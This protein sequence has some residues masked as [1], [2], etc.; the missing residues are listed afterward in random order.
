MIT[1]PIIPIWLMSIICV[2]LLLLKKRGVIPYIRQMIMIILLFVI[3][4]RIMVPDGTMTVTTQK[5]NTKVLFVVD[6]T[7][8][9]VAKDDGK[10]ERLDN[11][12]EDCSYIL[13]ELNGAKFAVISFNNEAHY[14]APFTNNG[15]YIDGVIRAIYP[16]S[17]L[18]A[19]GSSMN[20][21]RTMATDVLK[22][23][24]EDG[25]G[26]VV[27]FF[28]SDGEIT[29]N[30][31]LDNFMELKKYVDYG[32]VLGYGTSQGGQM[33]MQGV[34][35]EEKTVVEDRRDYPYK[36]A[37]SKIDE[38]NLKQIAKDIGINYIH[39]EQSSDVDR[40]LSEIKA[41]AKTE[42][43]DKKQLGYRDIYYIFVVPF[44]LLLMYEIYDMRKRVKVI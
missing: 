22:G 35:D 18:Y 43:Q 12:R 38:T 42:E 4:L 6:A 31:K 8:S 32:A 1:N 24:K 9:M 41:N 13:Q 20:I 26:D 2:G 27:L 19:K 29:N 7:I 28:I 17:D 37:V 30:E 15:D 16:L 34:F 14:L 23:A 5:M 39:M 3:N 33:E 44:L 10:R 25:S 21:W 11:V 36:P 40:V